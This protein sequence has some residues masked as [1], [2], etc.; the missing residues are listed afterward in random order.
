MKSFSELFNPYLYYIISVIDFSGCPLQNSSDAGCAG[1]SQWLRRPAAG[2]RGVSWF[3]RQ[4]R[5]NGTSPS[6]RSYGYTE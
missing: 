1:R 2:A 6:G 4:E 3:E 5:K